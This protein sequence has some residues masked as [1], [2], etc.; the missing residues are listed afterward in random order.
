MRAL[1]ERGV[2]ISN[3]HRNGLYD[4]QGTFKR[5]PERCQSGPKWTCVTVNQ[6]VNHRCLFTINVGITKLLISLE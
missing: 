4:S 1:I 5:G 2:R 3:T 6:T